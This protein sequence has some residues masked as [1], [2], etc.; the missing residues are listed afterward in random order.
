MRNQS[1]LFANFICRFGDKVFMDVLKEIVYPAFFDDTLIRTYG[2][3]THYHF[4][5]VFQINF[6][7]NNATPEIAIC[8]H[9]IKD[10][11]LSRTQIFDEKK[12]LVRDERTMR[13]SPSSF[14]VLVLSNHKLIY[15]PETPHAPDL[16]AFK[17]TVA[18]FLRRK[19][20]EFINSQFR[21]AETSEQGITK[22]E[23]GASY[24]PP[25]VKIV[26]LTGIDDIDAF[27]DRFAKLQ[28]MEFYLLK[29]N[30]EIDGEK[31]F[32]GAK[33]F[34]DELEP[35]S[36]K[37][38]TSKPDGFDSEQAK[39][40]ILGAT[41]AGNQE[42]IL[43][44]MDEEGNKLSG[45]NDNFKITSEIE[46]VPPNK[47]RFARNLFRIF[48]GLIENG[49]IRIDAQPDAVIQNIREKLR[50]LL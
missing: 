18:D 45:N 49:A 25:E 15:F 28:R 50:T 21:M 6:N 29:T 39:K 16:T 43:R 40:V 35:K 46:V 9:F 27:V 11:T 24:P 38:I 17:S 44:G 47:K 5:D 30:A 32:R 7:D 22:K 31:V 34:L 4:Y 2:K 8:G 14:F 42:I 33:E 1:A 12:G 26:P 36:T 37:L 3:T 19:R 48:S 20:K 10:T 23:L 13:S 41:A